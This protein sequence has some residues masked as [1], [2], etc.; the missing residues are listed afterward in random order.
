MTKSIISKTWIIGLIV[1]IAGLVVGG[2]GVWLLLAFGGQFTTA[3]GGTGTEFTPEI[4][5]FFWTTIA[6]MAAGFTIALAGFVA[7]TVAWIGALINTY[8]VE[9]KLWFI[10]LLV[11]G[12]LGFGF[13]LVGYA[14]MIAYIIGGP[15]GTAI[16]QPQG[17]MRV[18]QPRTFAPTG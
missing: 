2:I 6:L 9:D 5:G 7:Q 1:V 17:P 14:V 10:M 16:Q 4:N 8:H 15:D 11:A 3:P 13:P 18:P 12:V